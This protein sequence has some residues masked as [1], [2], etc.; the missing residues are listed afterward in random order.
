MWDHETVSPSGGI[1]NLDF[2][3]SQTELYALQEVAMTCGLRDLCTLYEIINYQ[4]GI[5]KF[6]R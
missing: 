6:R 3:V 4:L 5:F 2:L 1:S